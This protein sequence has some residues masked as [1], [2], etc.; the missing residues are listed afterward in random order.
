MADY[1]PKYTITAFEGEDAMLVWH[2]TPLPLPCL[3]IRCCTDALLVAWQGSTDQPP[4]CLFRNMVAAGN[5]LPHFSIHRPTFAMR[6][7]AFWLSAR[8]I[9]SR[10]AMHALVCLICSFM[11]L[12]I[13]RTLACCTD[14]LVECI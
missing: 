7:I 9:Q 6:F 1:M 11:L 8:R 12:L 5:L 10:P 3:V 13:R 4:A 2:V 14:D